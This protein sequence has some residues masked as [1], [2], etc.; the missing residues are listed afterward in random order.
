MGYCLSVYCWHYLATRP[1]LIKELINNQNSY[2][3]YLPARHACG[4]FEIA[5]FNRE[6]TDR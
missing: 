2:L 3:R 6:A 1:R 4:R 5:Q